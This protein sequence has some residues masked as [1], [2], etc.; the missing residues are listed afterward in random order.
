[1]NLNEL[2][3]YSLFT[4][5]GIKKFVVILDN[6]SRRA[7][8]I[9]PISATRRRRETN[10]KGNKKSLKI[11]LPIIDTLSVTPTNG[12][13]NQ[14]VEKIVLPKRKNRLKERLPFSSLRGEIPDS[15]FKL[16]PAEASILLLTSIIANKIKILI[17]PTYRRICAAA[18]KSAF[19][20]KKIAAI[21]TKTAPNKKA[22][23]T[24]LGS[25]TTPSEPIIAT[26]DNKKKLIFCIFSKKFIDFY[27]IKINR[28]V[29]EN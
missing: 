11:C 10:S 23:Y 28:F 20:N 14:A 19:N 13:V 2:Q 9:A 26:K 27:L 3:N 12:E 21:Q 25:N 4:F 5:E 7:K 6:C 18:I 8:I 29:K 22:A 16:A 15:F 1:V 17:A 24:K